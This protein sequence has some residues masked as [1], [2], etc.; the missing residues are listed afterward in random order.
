VLLS[1]NGMGEIA[2]KYNLVGSREV[3]RLVDLIAAGN[4]TCLTETRR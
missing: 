3:S 2:G 1:V 4:S